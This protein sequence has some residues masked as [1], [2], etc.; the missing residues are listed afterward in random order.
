MS[1]TVSQALP[2]ATAAALSANRGGRKYR[3][4]KIFPSGRADRKNARV[5]LICPLT[6]AW[7]NGVGVRTRAS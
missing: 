3:F 6:S 7:E 4:G 5:I 1:G 2:A